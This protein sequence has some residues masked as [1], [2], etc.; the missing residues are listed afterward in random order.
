[1]NWRE[2]SFWVNFFF[3]KIKNKLKILTSRIKIWPRLQIHDFHTLN[4]KI[5]LHVTYSPDSTSTFFPVRQFDG[6]TSNPPASGVISVEPKSSQLSLF[7]KS[8]ALSI[9]PGVVNKLTFFNKASVSGFIPCRRQTELRAQQ[10]HR[11][12]LEIGP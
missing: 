4:T 2:Y 10:V 8:S 6:V 11:A 1:M 7:T 3:R 5:Y 9:G 12:G